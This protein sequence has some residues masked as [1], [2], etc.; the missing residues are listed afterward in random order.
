MK[1]GPARQ[2]RFR[3][4]RALREIQKSRYFRLRN[5]KRTEITCETS[6][7]VVLETLTGPNPAWC[8]GCGSEQEMVTPEVAAAIASVSTRLIYRWI[9]AGKLHFLEGSQGSLLICSKS[10]LAFGFSQPGRGE[11]S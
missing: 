6:R 9:E 2:G 1:R 3:I 4:Y 8:A 11:D 10:L 7:F 5:R